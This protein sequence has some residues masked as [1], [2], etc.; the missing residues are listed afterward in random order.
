M[1]IEDHVGQM[2]DQDRQVFRYDTFGSENFWGTSSSFTKGAASV[3]GWMA[4]W[5]NPDLTDT[6]KAELVEYLKSL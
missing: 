4:G 3:A 6:E 2:M 5:P 1:V